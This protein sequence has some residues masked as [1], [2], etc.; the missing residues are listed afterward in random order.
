MTAPAQPPTAPKK[1]VTKLTF[2]DRMRIVREKI[3]SEGFGKDVGF[4]GGNNATKFKDTEALKRRSQE[5]FNEQ[6]IHYVA[7]IKSVKTDI[8]VLNSAQGQK[9]QFLTSGEYEYDFY[10]DDKLEYTVTSFGA[11]NNA[12]ATQATHG[13]FTAAESS[14][15]F[16]ILGANLKSEEEFEAG[17]VK[18]ENLQDSRVAVEPMTDNPYAR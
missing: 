2:W 11:F 10:C 7:K 5:L 15:L 18:S 17:R 9:T 4:K 1:P 16:N 13:S 3:Q 14:L 6:R 12:S 8:I